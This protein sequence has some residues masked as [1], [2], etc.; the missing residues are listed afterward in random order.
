[1]K[2][3]RHIALC[4]LAGALAVPVFAQNTNPPAWTRSS[5]MGLTLTRGN[6]E[7]MTLH[8]DLSAERKGGPNEYRFAAEGNYGETET[9]ED[10]KKRTTANIRNAK[11][12]TEVRHLLTDRMYTYLS[13]ELM[14]DDIAGLDYRLTVGPGLGRYLV[15]TPSTDISVESGFAYI[16]ERMVDGSD[17]RMALR[18]AQKAE[19]KFSASAKVWESAEYLPSLE[20]FSDYLINAEM[21]AEA[22]M[23]ARVSLKVVAQDKYDSRPAESREKNDLTVIAGLSF[24]L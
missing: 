1:M 23:T 24:K 16:H 15:R 5:T 2:L 14:H 6:S 13:A 22:A 12:I 11:G 17:D 7:T 19:H 3:I 21:G 8:A 18:A 10:G 9:T 4:A 20:D